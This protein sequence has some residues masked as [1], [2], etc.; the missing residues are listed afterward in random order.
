MKCG[1]KL[2][3]LPVMRVMVIAGLFISTGLVSAQDIEKWE[4]A[5]RVKITKLS[6]PVYPPLARTAR[7]TGDVTVNVSVRPDGTIESVYAVKGIQ[8]SH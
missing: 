1:F 4:A 8:F 2:P 3:D 7:I 6:V 5:S